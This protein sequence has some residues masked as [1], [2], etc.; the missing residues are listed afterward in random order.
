MI[1]KEGN[2][3]RI[4]GNFT[5]SRKGVPFK[6][7]DYLKRSFDIVDDQM[8]SHDQELDEEKKDGTNQNTP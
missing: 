3:Y 1:F 6:K 4:H 8:E 7:K 5:E 2:P